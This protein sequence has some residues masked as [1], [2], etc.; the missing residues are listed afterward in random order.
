MD[1][2]EK[3]LIRMSQKAEREARKKRRAGITQFQYGPFSLWKWYKKVVG[4]LPDCMK[5]MNVTDSKM[6]EAII[7][8][9]VVNGVYKSGH[10]GK[11]YKGILG[12]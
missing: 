8:D 11:F 10:D 5:L 1:H 6:L 7:M 4:H 2:S 3:K 12:R 9:E